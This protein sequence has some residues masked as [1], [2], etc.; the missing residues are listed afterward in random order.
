MIDGGTPG[1][2]HLW[3]MVDAATDAATYVGVPVNVQVGSICKHCFYSGNPFPA[4]NPYPI[5]LAGKQHTTVHIILPF[6]CS[7]KRLASTLYIDLLYV[8]SSDP[9]Y[10]LLYYIKWVTTSWSDSI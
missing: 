4:A 8:Q 2:P 10:V 6:K 3:K 5:K 9:F 7:L 1:S